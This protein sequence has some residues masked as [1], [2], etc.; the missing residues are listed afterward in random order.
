MKITA[1]F[2]NLITN[3]IEMKKLYTL[4][5]LAL[6]GA[7]FAQ[8]PIITGIMDGDCVG[9]VPK[10]LEIYASGT[11]DFALY[12]VEN[13]TNANTTWGSA[14][15]LAPLGT[16]T[17]DFVY[18]IL[19]GTP[20]GTPTPPDNMTTFTTEFPSI[21]TNRVLNPP[22]GTG[23]P[24]PLNVN[25]DDRL[26]IIS[27]A[28][29]AV[30]DQFGMEGVDGSGTTWE[31]TD[32]WAKRNNGTGPD[33]ATFNTANWTFAAVGSLD[34]LGACQGGAV[35]DTVVPFGDYSLAVAQNSINGLRLYPNPVV[36]GTLYID[37]DVNSTKSVVIYDIVGKQVLKAT[38]T[39]AVNV[40][41]LNG[42]VYVVKITEDGK[43]AT[44]KLV[45]R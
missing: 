12:T 2:A 9:G 33:G 24:Q 38:T 21:P 40:S 42:G 6:T 30:I 10:V 25:G 34:G 37:T 13:Q 15:S 43:T 1:I 14:L 16:V 41:N 20:T 27:N 28:T 18:I 31:Y 39:N 29:S 35:Y 4:L 22:T 32:S 44:R 19:G 23:L 8:T 26:R 17:N 3:N 36:N 45:I 5:F 11:V 7:T